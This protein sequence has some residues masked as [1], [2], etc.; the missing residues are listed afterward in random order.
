MK[1]MNSSMVDV[2]SHVCISAEHVLA[3]A[4]TQ[5]SALILERDAKIS[6]VAD[7]VLSHAH[8]ARYRFKWMRRDPI[9]T[10]RDEAIRILETTYMYNDELL[11]QLN[12]AKRLHLHE[13]TALELLIAAAQLS[14]SHGNGYIML[15]LEH[16]RLIGSVPMNAISVQ[17][18]NRVRCEPDRHTSAS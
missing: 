7:A 13:L 15:S 16:V 3:A 4:S 1:C 12:C 2:T 6:R 18:Q 14:I 5:C 11:E 17:Q 9:P 8:N 10:S